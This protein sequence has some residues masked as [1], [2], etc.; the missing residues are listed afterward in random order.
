MASSAPWAASS[1]RWRTP[2]SSP[3]TTATLLTFF[4]YTALILGGAG[5]IFGPIVGAILF[6]G[7][8]VFL[9]NVLVQAVRADYIPSAIMDSN[10]VGIVRGILVGV[11]PHAAHD[12]PPAGPVRRQEGAGPRCPLTY[13]PP[14]DRPPRTAAPGRAPRCR[15]SRPGPGVPK[16]DPILVADGVAR[17]FGGL[18]AVDVEHLEVQ[19]GVI[20]ALIGPNGAGKTT[21]F[22]LLTG[23]DPPDEGSWSFEGKALAGVPA[24]RSPG[25]AWCAPSS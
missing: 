10:Q 19:R 6:S 11:L 7:L 25:A 18:T 4:A 8:F 24:T 17:R 23:F 15:T 21:F 2:R 3:T 12:L 22:N 20:T 13:P 14:I 1:S 9:E 16:P 5:R